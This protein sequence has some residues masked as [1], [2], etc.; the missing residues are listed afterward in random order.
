M[1]TKLQ[2]RLKPKDWKGEEFRYKQIKL[3]GHRLTLIKYDNKLEAYGRTVKP[4]FEFSIK[5]PDIAKYD[6]WEAFQQ[7]PNNS[8]V[9]GEIYLIGGTSSDVVHHL[10]E[11]TGQLYF[12]SFAVP[13]WNGY[14]KRNGSLEAIDTLLKSETGETLTSYYQYM[15]ELD[16]RERML[17]DAKMLYIE[18]WVLKQEN[19]CDWYKLKPT[20]TIDVVV[21]GF[22]DGRGKYLGGVGAIIGHCYIDGEW[23]NICKCSGM[24]DETR[25]AIDEDKDLGRVFE[26]MYDCVGAKGKLRFPRFVRWRDDKPREECIYRGVDL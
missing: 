2:D 17:D 7:I 4:E 13:W 16:T 24:N 26:V 19:Y 25:W 11:Q 20:K 15:P 9:D 12:S 14:D 10:V 6:W 1:L 8:M 5:Y 18:G 23:T 21:T 22:Q 3:D